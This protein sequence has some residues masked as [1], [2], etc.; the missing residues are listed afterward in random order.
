M[1]LRAKGVR[2]H[3][4]ETSTWRIKT[5]ELNLLSAALSGLVKDPGNS[6][7]S[8]MGPRPTEVCG[9]GLVGR[10]GRPQLSG[11]IARRCA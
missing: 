5:E 10:L 11:F 4:C 7:P 9:L 2:E 3:E 6:M 1:Q 8:P